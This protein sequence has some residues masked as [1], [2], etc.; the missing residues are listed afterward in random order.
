MKNTVRF[1]ILLWFQIC[2]QNSNRTKIMDFILS[3][4]YLRRKNPIV[5][6]KYITH[7]MKH[8]LRVNYSTKIVYSLE[9]FNFI[10]R[11]SKIYVY[12][13]GCAGKKIFGWARLF[14]APTRAHPWNFLLGGRLIY[15]LFYTKNKCFLLMYYIIL[16]NCRFN[17]YPP[18]I[19]SN[20][21]KLYSYIKLIKCRK[22]LNSNKNILINGDM[23]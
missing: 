1:I 6:I 17:F 5:S 2:F 23:D 11:I 9:D 7:R 13:Q 3:S 22:A 18:Y 21:Y 4:W 12:C 19:I 8:T 20:K 16:F 14:S 10:E 15:K